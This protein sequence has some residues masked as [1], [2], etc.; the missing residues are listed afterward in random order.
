[1]KLKQFTVKN[2]KCFDQITLDFSK[3]RDY[4]NL[5][6][7]VISQ[8]DKKTKISNHSLLYGYNGSGKT[9]LCLALMDISKVLTD[10]ERYDEGFVFNL[11]KFRNNSRNNYIYFEYIFD[12]DGKELVYSYTKSDLYDLVREKLVYDGNLVFSYFFGDIKDQNVVNIPNLEHFATIDLDTKNS[13]VRYIQKVG[14][15][16]GKEI[17]SLIQ[18]ASKMLYFRSTNEGNRY[19]GYKK[20]VSV[21]L[22][23]IAEMNLINEYKEF[24]KSAGLDYELIRT[25]N[26]I[27]N[28]PTIA[29][30]MGEN[31]LSFDAV[32]SSGTKVLTLFFFWLQSFNEL[33]FII[34]DEYDAYYH[35]SLAK[36]I[37]KIVCSFPAQTLVTT[38]NNSLLSYDYTRPDCVYI[39]NGKRIE[40]LSTLASEFNMK[41]IRKGNSM[42]NIYERFIEKMK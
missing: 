12:C 14:N 7:D 5:S 41:E 37:Y 1:M 3:T 29:V 20:G 32:A 18:F 11:Y 13:M 4:T 10:F 6:E 39:T 38:H 36:M 31:I 40:N 26:I 30:K 33:S 35:D 17:D 42:K 34:I 9:S 16:N 2:F 27:T 28:K 25:N 8:I 21:L 15:Y 24:L 19:I 22:D 23:E